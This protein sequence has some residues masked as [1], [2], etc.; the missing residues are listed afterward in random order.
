MNK[1]YLERV[2]RGPKSSLSSWIFYR[3]E[4]RH[5]PQEI[6]DN[7]ICAG[8]EDAHVDACQVQLRLFDQ[9]TSL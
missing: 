4:S 7:M 9:G 6:T 5:V 2:L 3:F 8:F 1:N